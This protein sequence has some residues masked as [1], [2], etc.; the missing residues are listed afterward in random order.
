M[1]VVVKRTVLVS[2]LAAAARLAGC[3]GSSSKA[4]ASVS[5]SIPPA[6]STATSTASVPLTTSAPAPTSSLASSGPAACATANLGV[7]LGGD[8]GA[9][10]SV[11]YQLHFVNRGSSACTMTGYPGVSFVAPGNGQQVGRAGTRSPAP[12]PV[13][14]LTPEGEATATVQVAE[15]QNFTAADCGSTAVSGL[16]VCPPANAAA[17]YVKFPGSTQ[18]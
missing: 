15:A 17:A 13:V 5:S 3:G 9:A 4:G 6:Q 11:Y 1:G 10:G 14:T 2:S 8:M 16:R 7:S 12:T 18:Q